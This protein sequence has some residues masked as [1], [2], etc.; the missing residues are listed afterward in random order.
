MQERRLPAV[1]LVKVAC[2][3]LHVRRQRLLRIDCGGLDLTEAPP[4]LKGNVTVTELDQMY[5]TTSSAT[6][7]ISKV[8]LSGN[9]FSSVPADY[10]DEVASTVEEIRMN[11]IAT[12]TSLESGTFANKPL[13]RAVLLHYGGLTSLPANL[14]TNSPNLYR[15]WMNDNSISTVH[16]D[17]FRGVTDMLKEVRRGGCEERSDEAS[18]RP[19]ANLVASLGV[20]A[21]HLQQFH[22]LVGHHYF[23]R[24]DGPPSAVD[25]EQ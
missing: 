15:V 21:L 3:V 14:F 2:L 23:Q 5:G 17:T 25:D 24:H 11:N 20:A 22:H 1:L 6:Y 8:W 10:F 7:P 13:L 12:L 16:P 18:S 19:V 4:I 9:A